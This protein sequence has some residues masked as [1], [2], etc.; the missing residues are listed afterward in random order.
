MKRVEACE[1]HIR[2]YL[3]VA[4]FTLKTTFARL[5]VRFALCD[6]CF[7]HFTGA[8]VYIGARKV[9][10]INLGWRSTYVIWVASQACVSLEPSSDL[11]CCAS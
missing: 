10:G 7:G 1:G 4:L 11:D 5:C 3:C 6:A 2:S 9:D 8:C